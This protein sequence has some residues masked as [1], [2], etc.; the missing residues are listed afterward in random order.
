MYNNLVG[1]HA[2]CPYIVCPMFL[3]HF[4]KYI[5]NFMSSRCKIT[6]HIKLGN[7]TG[8]FHSNFMFDDL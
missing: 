5:W 2:S 4:I 1:T 3:C 6:E 7:N 8:V